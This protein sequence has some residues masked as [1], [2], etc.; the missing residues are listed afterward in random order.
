M[1]LSKFDTMTSLLFAIGE[2]EKK[3]GS[4]SQTV[5]FIDLPKLVPLQYMRQF[6]SL[7]KQR[8]MMMG[9]FAQKPAQS[10]AGNAFFLLNLTQTL[11]TDRPTVTV[12]LPNAVED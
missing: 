7:S 10:C 3:P 8:R 1:S 12:L 11:P 2:V 5:G 6:S 9:A 4:F